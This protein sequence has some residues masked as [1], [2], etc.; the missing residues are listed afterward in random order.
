MGTDGGC[1]HP[2][3]V[4]FPPWV[5]PLSHPQ[6]VPIPSQALPS[7][8]LFLLLSQLSHGPHCFLAICTLH[9]G[10]TQ[11]FLF[12]SFAVSLT[13]NEV[14]KGCL[15]AFRMIPREFSLTP[16]GVRSGVAGF[17]CFVL[18]FSPIIYFSSW[19]RR[20]KMFCA[21]KGEAQPLEFVMSEQEP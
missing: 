11:V 5:L 17:F 15:G 3:A 18:F 9:F 2:K 16:T 14:G 21:S 12:I 10:D 1:P 13:K 6:A 4:P 8:P 20:K 19:E 7:W